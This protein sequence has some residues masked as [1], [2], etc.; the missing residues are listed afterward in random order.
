GGCGRGTRRRRRRPAPNV[1]PPRQPNLLLLWSD[2][3]R[4][5]VMPGPGNPVLQA[6]H[7]AA[8]ARSSYDFRRAYCTSPVC[9]P[10][11]GSILT[12]LWPHHHGALV[13]N[14]PLRRDVRTIAEGLP[15]E[16]VTAYFGKWH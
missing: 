11:R 1:K 5:D 6:P 13:N 8:L 16:Y 9:T 4:A 7:L 2:Q 12:G 3:H 10:S 14:T 15:A